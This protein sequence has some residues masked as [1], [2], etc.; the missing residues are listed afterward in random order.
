MTQP[1]NPANNMEPSPGLPP[2]FQPDSPQ[3]HPTQHPV[4]P[5]PGYDPGQRP[6]QQLGLPYQGQ[7]PSFEPGFPP[8]P[9]YYSQPAPK[10]S[11]KLLWIGLSSGFAAGV[12]AT[13]LVAT[14]VTAVGAASGPSFQSAAEEC[15]AAHTAGIS[16]GDKGSSITIDTKGE[17]DSSGASFDD[18]SCILSALNIPDSVTSQI[19]DTSAMDGRQS[20][21]WE[22]V[23]ASWTYHPDSGMKLI[24]SKAKR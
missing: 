11:K 23:D 10:Q 7:Q 6:A 3:G 15:N 1:E 17:D 9:Q 19:D 13:V 20:A 16:V 4:P 24:L 12:L 22:G 21:S 5:H 14:I 8:A 18:A 2:R